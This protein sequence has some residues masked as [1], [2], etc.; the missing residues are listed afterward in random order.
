MKPY[1]FLLPLALALTSCGGGGSGG[2]GNNGGLLTAQLVAN[3][4]NFASA[5]R[6]LP[7]GDI[8]F[9]ELNTGNV[10]IVDNG[11]LLPTPVFHVDVNT[12]GERGLL[13]LAIDPNYASNNFVYIFYTKSSGTENE[14]LRFTVTNNVG[15]SATPIVSGLP[16]ANNHDGGR[17]AFGP[18]GKLYMTLGDVGTSSNSQSDAT[19]AGKVLRYN[20]N[21]TIPADNP[22]GG[23]PMFAK[24]LRNPFGLAIDPNTGS[25]I[26]SE[27]GPGCGDEINLVTSGANYGWPTVPCGGSQVGFVDP[28]YEF[29]EIVAP[30]G[31]AFGTGAY[32]G[33]LLVGNFVDPSD[34]MIA[35]SLLQFDLSTMASGSIGPPTVRYNSSAPIIDVAMGPDDNPY[36]CTSAG[37]ILRLVP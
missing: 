20:P 12:D 6:F 19:P 21:G 1:P 28:L 37:E 5:L 22:I 4:G 24:G 23:N 3:S 25:V 35:R 32:D 2:G 30:T 31:I 36:I 15:G 17:L 18:D 10:R 33:T 29:P 34:P 26:V 8:L 9:T 27:N 7:D 13:G 11:T 14:V 16:A